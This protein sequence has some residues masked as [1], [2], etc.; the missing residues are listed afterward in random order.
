M[1]PSTSRPTSRPWMRRLLSGTA[2][3]ALLVVVAPP[4]VAP[5]APAPAAF[6][7][8]TTPTGGDATTGGTGGATGGATGGTGGATG[9]TGATPPRDPQAEAEAAAKRA[10]EK[11]ARDAAETAREQ[12]AQA[13]RDAAEAQ[14]KAEER[15]RKAAIQLEIATQK[16][17]DTWARRGQPKRLIIVRPNQIDTV[18]DGR[19][20]KRTARSGVLTIQTLARLV[21]TSF[22]DLN[23]DTAKLDAAVVLGPTT[24]LDI[25]GIKTL[26]LGGGDSPADAAFLY[27]GSGRILVKGVTVTSANKDGQPL[28]MA[29]QGR[30]FIVVS[31][32]GRFEAT[33]AT[34]SDLGT[35][36]TGTAK[37]EPGISFNTDST[38]A[39]VRTQVLRNTVG[40][41]LS[42]SG[43]VRIEDTTFAEA[44]EDG[45]FLQGDKGTTLIGVKAERNGSNGVL[46]AGPSS[47]R[48]ITNISTAGNHSYG[49]AVQGQDKLQISA[50]T[51]IGDGAGGVRIN[52]CT[53]CVVKDITTRDQPIG[54]YMHV[55]TTNI[56]L[57]GLHLTGGRR[58]VVAEKTTKGATV[59][60]STID[61][62]RVAG[63]A[64]GGHDVTVDGITI[65][66]ARTAVRIERGAGNVQITGAKFSGGQDG[67]VTAAGTTGIVVK[68][69]VADGIV[70]D[71]VRNFS[72]GAQILG[73]RITGGLTGIDAEAGTTISGTVVGLSN[74]GIR[75]RSV[76][77]VTVD[78]VSVD[79]VTVGL[80]V[81]VG[82]P[83]VLTKSR[84]HALE[85]VRG[86]LE[87]DPTAGND[88]SLPT[89]NL[90]GAIGVPLVILAVLLEVMHSIRQRRFGG[91]RRHAPPT[92]PATA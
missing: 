66:D 77:P 18:T 12:A 55:N 14:R 37:G 63:V 20:T 53:D 15:A 41:E 35:L 73:G 71:A 81:A 82:T 69:L 8:A 31:A 58:G 79:A 36:S 59:T 57:S 39:L 24:V 86:P 34:L 72:P 61:G 38:G 54:L 13:A 28:P 30:P 65:T 51:A 70:N 32:R 3:A 23:G 74:E 50:I 29:A 9:A 25:S 67:L 60:D 17:R 26:Q 5:A 80:N 43:G 88:L 1:S 52:R 85:A 48:P 11:A 33:D 10:A 91:L 75:A 4:G 42:S 68:D 87:P 40:A 21:P 47:D 64:I 27:T 6:V 90:L 49:V 56:Q 46:V 89:I 62:P 76:E 16:A 92:L 44:A 45:L 22:L 2:V 84:V 78:N 83:V 7:P 19:L